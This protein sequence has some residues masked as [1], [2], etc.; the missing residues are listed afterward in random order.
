M[1]YQLT[2]PCGQTFVESSEDELVEHVEAHLSSVHG[3]AYPRA[4]ILTM[5]TVVP[6]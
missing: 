5:A 4:A 2:C 3:R 6:D 1:T